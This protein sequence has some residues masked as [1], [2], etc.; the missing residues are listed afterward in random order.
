MSEAENYYKY[1]KLTVSGGAS[2]GITSAKRQA[3]DKVNYVYNEVVFTEF[4]S[5][6]K[7]NIITLV[8]DDRRQP[9]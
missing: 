9:K 5:E 2:Y 3:F 6:V 8:S 7:N 4:A 1:K